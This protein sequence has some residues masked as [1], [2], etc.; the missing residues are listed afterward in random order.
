MNLSYRIDTD[1][2]LTEDEKDQLVALFT[3][4]CRHETKTRFRRHLDTSSMPNYGIF[5]RVELNPVEY[6]AGQDYPGEIRTV[7]D[8]ILKG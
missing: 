8:L 1:T 6:T 5:R 3:A 7:R 2:P 4:K